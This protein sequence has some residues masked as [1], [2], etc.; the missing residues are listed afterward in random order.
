MTVNSSENQLPSHNG[1]SQLDRPVALRDLL[2]GSYVSAFKDAGRSNPPVLTAQQRR[3]YAAYVMPQLAGLSSSSRILDVGCGDGSLLEFLKERGFSNT[4][5]VDCSAEQI[6]RAAARGVRA[7]EGNLFAAL[8][9]EAG[10]CDVV[11]AIDVIEH[12]TKS[13]LVRFGNAVH[14]ALK[15]GGRFVIQTPNGEGL[16]AGHIIYG[17]LTHE[18]IFN[19]SS[20]PQYL[21]AFGFGNVR[22][23]ETGPIPHGIASWCRLVMWRVWRTFAQLGAMAQSGRLPRVLTAVM[24]ARCEKLGRVVSG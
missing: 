2:Y 14:R 20:L 3:A 1:D 4:E 13:E 10:T 22:V 15:P 19:D 23:M 8:E 12:L 6:K 16:F 18:T 7:R 17:D 11:V 24:I 21:R 9:A 5:G